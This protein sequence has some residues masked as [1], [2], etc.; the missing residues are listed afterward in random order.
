MSI[1]CRLSL[2]LPL[3]LLRSLLTEGDGASLAK[4]R[5]SLA[6]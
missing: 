3:F 2:R 6:A 1:A 5:H 4:A